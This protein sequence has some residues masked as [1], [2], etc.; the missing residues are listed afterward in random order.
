MT[1]LALQEDHKIVSGGSFTQAS[2]VTRNRL[3]RLNSDGSLDPAINFGSGANNF[4]SSVVIQQDDRLVLGGGFTQ[5]NGCA[6][7]SYIARLY[8]LINVLPG[9]GTLSFVSANFSGQ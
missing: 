3:T 5:F 7:E 1:C 6:N 9:P 4:V 2:G 8:G